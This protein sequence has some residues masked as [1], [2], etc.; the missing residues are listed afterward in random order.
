MIFGVKRG[1][2][3]KAPH[4]GRFIAGGYLK[5]AEGGV[6]MS[7]AASRLDM[8]REHLSRII[9]GRKPVSV[10]LAMK[11]E[12]IGWATA[13]VWMGLQTAYDIAQARKR[14]NQ[15]RESAP[16]LRRVEQLEREY[17]EQQAEAAA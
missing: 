5:P 16:A 1:E 9:H 13:E 6:S 10:D 8:S 14:L 4:P 7:E 15:P 11:L 2:A 3:A 17:D 12:A